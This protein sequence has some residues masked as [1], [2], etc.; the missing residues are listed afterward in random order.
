MKEKMQN[1]NELQIDLSLLS[2]N[3]K[4]ELF[5]FYRIL[6][7][8]YQHE[9]EDA[10]KQSSSSEKKEDILIGLFEGPPDLAS[11]S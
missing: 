9:A 4:T 7:N 1:S 8:K 2:D 10:Q 3:A 6:L 11:C 5:N